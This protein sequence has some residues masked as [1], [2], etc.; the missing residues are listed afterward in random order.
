VPGTKEFCCTLISHFG[1]LNGPIALCDASKGRFN[2]DAITS[3]TP[4]VAWPGYWPTSECFR[5]P[6]PIA[7][8]YFLVSHAPR[9]RFALYAIDRYGNREIL[10]ID[11]TVGSM[12]P[13]PLRP[14]PAPP[15]L[16]LADPADP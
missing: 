13:T 1:D 14:V 9:D 4:E 11:M 3:I 8:D 5:D 10:Y 15:V 12:C 6:V 7:T 2:P 16:D